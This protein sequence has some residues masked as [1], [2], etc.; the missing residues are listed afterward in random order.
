GLTGAPSYTQFFCYVDSNGVTQNVRVD[1]TRIAIHP[2]FPTTV[3]AWGYDNFFQ[4][5]DY[6]LN[7]ISTI[8]LPNHLA[9][10]FSYDPA[11]GVLS[12]VTLPTGGYIRYEWETIAQRKGIPNP[13]LLTYTDPAQ[14][15][16]VLKNR[17]ESEDGVNEQRW[18]YT[19][20]GT[21]NTGWTTTV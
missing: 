16:L 6:S 17:Y 7:V 19:Y 8:A 12:K 5:G 18:A 4:N 3:S 21:W 20:T 15:V 9:Y 13:S 10:T 11:F 14:D 2:A 1:W